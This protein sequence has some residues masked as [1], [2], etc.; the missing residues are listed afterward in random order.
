MSDGPQEMIVQGAGWYWTW[1]RNLVDTQLDGKLLV[2]QADVCPRVN[3][4]GEGV[5]APCQQKPDVKQRSWAESWTPLSKTP[6][7]TAESSL[8]LGNMRLSARPG[9]SRGRGSPGVV[10]PTPQASGWCVP[11][12]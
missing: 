4:G 11:L 12:C 7:S 3:E 10:A 1:Q 6:L 2:E 8:L 5:R 9:C